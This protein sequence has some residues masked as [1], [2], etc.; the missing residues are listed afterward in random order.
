MTV[1]PAIYSC[2]NPQPNSKQNTF[3]KQPGTSGE[4]NN[5]SLWPAS[6]TA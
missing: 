6:R 2:C 1:A 4:P 3:P 5:Y